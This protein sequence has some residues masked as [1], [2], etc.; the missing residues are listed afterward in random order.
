MSPRLV[1]LLPSWPARACIRRRTGNAGCCGKVSAATATHQPAWSDRRRKLLAV[2]DCPE[3]S[4]FRGIG[5]RSGY[6]RNVTLIG[7]R[8]LYVSQP[9]ASVDGSLKGTLTNKAFP[10][11]SAEVPSAIN[12]AASDE[13]EFGTAKYQPLLQKICDRFSSTDT[14]MTLHVSTNGVS[15]ASAESGESK[16]ASVATENTL[17]AFIRR[18]TS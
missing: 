13:L 2:S 16:A 12:R 4:K 5:R 10:L 8:Q 7:R 14:S 11:S 15:S 9:Q 3:L 18:C 1:C 17:F 6:F